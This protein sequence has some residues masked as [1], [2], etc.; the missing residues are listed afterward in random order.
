[1]HRWL[2]A[3]EL[4][5]PVLRL[6]DPARVTIDADSIVTAWDHEAE[7]LFGYSAAS[8]VGRPL[9]ELIVPEDLHKAHLR[10]FRQFLQRG[11]SAPLKPA[12][13]IDAVDAMGQRF[14]VKVVLSLTRDQDQIFF[15]ALIWRARYDMYGSHL[16]ATS[17]GDVWC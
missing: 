7:L 10:G 15:H 4:I 9:P 8:A 17:G 11:P 2:S 3:A 1:M 16:S 6:M 13:H 5:R 14:E 12:Y